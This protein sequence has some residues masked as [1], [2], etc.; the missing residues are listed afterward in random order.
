[1][2]ERKEYPLIELL[3]EH[4]QGCI[5]G[6]IMQK[7]GK[8]IKPQSAEN[9]LYLIKHLQDF[10]AR[11]K[12][13]LR[14]REITGR[15]MREWHAKKNYWQKFY[16]DFMDYLYDEADCYDNYWTHWQSCSAHFSTT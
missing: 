15:D 11:K 6:R 9:Y 7:N 13:A 12:I 10:S 14:I 1:M 4:M 3:N 5:N 16:R 8:R 2:K